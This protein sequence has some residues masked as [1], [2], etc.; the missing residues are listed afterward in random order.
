VSDSHAIEHVRA[1]DDV[2][3]AAAKK[4]ILR[5]DPE[6]LTRLARRPME[7]SEP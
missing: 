3:Q 6:G 5:L 2:L 7:I 1:G 4:A